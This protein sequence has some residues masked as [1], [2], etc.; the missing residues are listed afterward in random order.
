M[1]LDWSGRRI[2]VTGGSR[3][4][5]KAIVSAFA[6]Q[7]G[8]VHYTHRGTSSGTNEGPEQDSMPGSVTGHILDMQ[9]VEQVHTWASVFAES[10]KTLDVLVNNVGGLFRRSTFES[11]DLKLWR[12]ALELN[13][14]TVVSTT[15]GTLPALRAAAKTNGD[16]A[17][18]N[19]SSISALHGGGNDSTHYGASKGAVCTLTKGLAREFAKDRIRVNAIV[20]SAIDT[21]FQRVHSSP[22]RVQRIVDGTPLG[23]IGTVEDVAGSALFLADRQLSGYITGQLLGLDGGRT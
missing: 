20:P 2:L 4:I 14:L 8:E 7:G 19:I 12:D 23:R 22:E 17:I 16:A 9:D 3:G 6:N 1:L 13:V 15:K 21:D 5:G 10:Y 18:I 11:S